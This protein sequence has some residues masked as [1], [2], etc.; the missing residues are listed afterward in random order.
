M[1]KILVGILVMSVGQAF[2]GQCDIQRDNYGN[3]FVSE[4][5]R[6]MTNSKGSVASAHRDLENMINNRMCR[7]GR[8]ARSIRM[9]QCEIDRDN[10][11]NMYVKRDGSRFTSSK[12]SFNSGM[13][14]Y[15][16][17]VNL[18]LCEAPR[19]Q[20]VC[21]LNRD[22][23][24]NFFVS[25]GGQRMSSSKGSISSALNDKNDMV[26]SN[27]CYDEIANN[28]CE[29]KRDN[30]GNYFVAVGGERMSASKGSVNSAAN[31]KRELMNA[32]V[33]YDQ[34]ATAPC[35]VER[36]NYGNFY[37]SVN[38]ERMTSSKGSMNSALS[39]AGTLASENMCYL[40]NDR[41]RRDRRG[42]RR[43]ERRERTERDIKVEIA[44]RDANTAR[45]DHNEY[46]ACY[47]RPKSRLVTYTDTR[48]ARR[49]RGR[50]VG[51]LIGMIGGQV[52]GEVTGNDNLGDAISVVGAAVAIYGSVEV[53]NASEI[54]Y[55]DNGYDCQTHYQV[56][57]RVY[58]HR[59][60]RQ[61]CVTKRYYS[62]RWGSEHEYFETTCSGRRYMTFDRTTEI[63]YN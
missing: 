3:Y 28:A 43:S 49:G 21:E 19:S 57:R 55:L 30:Y 17:L 25:L 41:P 20:G 62:N 60:N 33:C 36:D 14:D 16:E 37:V 31:D 48:Q 53:A 1:K 59:V 7:N 45:Y 50:V 27:I 23:Y 11:G 18:G 6:R 46:L 10:Y 52:V 35:D 34:V 12:G 51:G 42:D 54:I 58:N 32:N 38:G 15:N 39:D 44:T 2:A 22:N 61:R 56:D 5:G 47:E 13:N 24:G 8:R 4:D 29:I 63:W 40:H 9:A 26:R